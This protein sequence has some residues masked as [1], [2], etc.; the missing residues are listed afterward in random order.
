MGIIT[1]YDV[2]RHLS[3]AAQGTPYSFSVEEEEDDATDAEIRGYAC[4]VLVDR[5]A[6]QVGGGYVAL[7]HYGY[8]TPGDAG[9]F[10]MRQLG[11]WGV[12]PSDLDALLP[13]WMAAIDSTVSA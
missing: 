7:N 5:L 8:G 2:A 13:A 3:K 4:N 11:T 6:F 10:Y 1:E 12:Q 9:T